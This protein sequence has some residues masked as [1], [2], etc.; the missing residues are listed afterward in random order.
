MLLLVIHNGNWKYTEKTWAVSLDD[1]QRGWLS[2]RNTEIQQC[3]AIWIEFLRCP[4]TVLL[5]RQHL[6]ATSQWVQAQTCKRAGI[7]AHSCLKNLLSW[8]H[9]T[10]SRSESGAL[11]VSSSSNPEAHSTFLLWPFFFCL[12]LNL[13]S[14]HTGSGG[15]SFTHLI[16]MKCAAQFI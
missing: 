13:K 15:G 11:Y 16:K 9:E 2:I 6:I 8:N 12:P 3:L 14:T 7:P 5:G 1:C 4:H 10:T